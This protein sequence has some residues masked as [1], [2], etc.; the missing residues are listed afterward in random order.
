MP[1]Y[2]TRAIVLKNMNLFETDR[3]VTL[4][5]EDHG[6]IKCVAKAARKIK[7]RFGAGLEP[8]SQIQ[9]VYFGKENQDLYRL[10]Q[11]DIQES[12][13]SIRENERKLYSG[14]YFLELA[15]IMLK[16]AH[17]EQE[18]FNLVLETLKALK[19]NSNAETLCRL[20]EMQMVSL[21]GYKPILTHCALCK[22]LPESKWI[23]FSY[24]NHGIICGHCANLEKTELKF[25]AGTLEY[26]KKLLTLEPRQSDRLKFPKGS[27]EEIERFSHRLVQI[28]L[29]REPNSYPFIKKMAVGL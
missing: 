17:R 4:L 9:V 27:E 12:F 11:C 19:Q 7:S 1:L 28:Q 20:F 5:T 23:G 2:K 21:S 8:M 26:L 29:G 15:D 14:I 13:Q 18:I 22:K 24:N 6:K 3:L 25:Q 16:E 10:N